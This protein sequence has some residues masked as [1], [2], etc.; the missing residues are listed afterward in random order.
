MAIKVKKKNFYKSEIEL[1]LDQTLL[2]L[3]DILPNLNISG[4]SFTPE[5]KHL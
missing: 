2:C 4:I 3:F 1:C 5:M